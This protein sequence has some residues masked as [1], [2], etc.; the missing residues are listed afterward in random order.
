MRDS[1]IRHVLF[2]GLDLQVIRHED[3]VAW[4][5]RRIAESESAEGWVI[6]LSL[7]KSQRE[8]FDTLTGQWQ[9]DE[10]EARRVLLGLLDVDLDRPLD[11]PERAIGLV[12]WLVTPGGDAADLE[13]LWN[14]ANELEETMFEADHGRLGREDVVAYERAFREQLAAFQDEATRQALSPMRV[15][16]LPMS[17]AV[18]LDYRA[19]PSRSLSVNATFWLTFGVVAVVSVFFIEPA[20]HTALRGRPGDS[21]L[22]CITLMSAL[23]VS[24]GLIA[25]MQAMRPSLSRA[26]AI[27]VAAMLGLS[28]WVPGY[29]F[30]WLWF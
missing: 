29:V 18:P 11:A 9:A 14:S 30:V 10:V 26:G 7:S 2:L 17:Q 19:E 1:L 23:I 4:A 22:G 16:L 6:D 15:Y 8:A 27:V 12:N 20:I 3:V 13:R 5:D 28:C 24:A 25:V 21:S